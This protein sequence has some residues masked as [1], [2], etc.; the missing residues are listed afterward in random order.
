VALE[1]TTRF[2]LVLML[3]PR[4]MESAL[5]MLGQV[6]GCCKN[7]MPLLLMDGHLPYPAAILQVFGQVK[8]RRRRK[9]RGRGRLKLKGLKP[10]PGLMAGVVDKVRDAAGNLLGVK[11]HVLFGRLKDI[12]QR[13]KKLKLGVGINTAH[14]ERFNATVRGRLAR[15]ARKTR[16]VSRRRTPLRAALALCRDVYNWVHPHGALNGATPAMASGLAT[17]VWTMK[18]YALYPVHAAEWQRA[19]WSEEQEIRIRSP[20]HGQKGL[21]VVPIS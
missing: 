10:P 3:A 12:R 14:V 6:A 21:K 7:K 18:R 8:H 15:L 2:A 9:G 16:D 20:L 17:E 1:V 19:I 5:Q 11:T 13:I 4:T